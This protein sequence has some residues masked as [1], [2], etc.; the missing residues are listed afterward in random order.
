MVESF[1]DGVRWGVWL[2]GV[3]TPIA[4]TIAIPVTLFRLLGRETVV[5]GELIEDEDDLPDLDFDFEGDPETFRPEVD[6]RYMPS[7]IVRPPNVVTREEAEKEDDD[8]D[9]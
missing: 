3:V 5:V 6:V 4:A 2:L 7:T 8:K 9:D 1:V